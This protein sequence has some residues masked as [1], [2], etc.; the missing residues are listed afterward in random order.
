MSRKIVALA[1]SA[2][3]LLAPA[4]AQAASRVKDIVEVEGV[5]KNQLVGYGIVVGLNGTGD[6]LRNSPFTKQS[7]EAMLE[8]LGVNTRDANLNTKNVAAVMVTAE[9]PAFA[10]SGS[11]V[12]VNVSALGDAK[13]LLGGTL[14]VT[15]LLGADGS[16]YA[17]GQGTVQTGAV[18]AGGASGSSIL[19]G[20]P[21]AGRIASGA[22]VEKESGFSLADM[23]EI[24]LTLRNPD[25]TTARRIAEAV[26][27]YQPK[28]AWAANPTVVQ[29][30]P[31]PGQ[32]PIAFLTAVEQ[33][34]VQPDTPAKV[35]IDE[36]NG[37]IVM[38]D[39]VRISTVAI[40]QGNLTISVQETPAVSQPLPFSRGGQTAVVPQTDVAVMEERGTQL[41]QLRSGASLASLVEGLNAL[42]VSPRD[43]I[44]ILQTIKAAGAL[45]AEIEV[46]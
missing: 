30:R 22:T 3:A 17:V 11:R 34:S 18:S 38:S 12:D 13:S 19:K 42:G 31:P 40:A 26:N 43:M 7:L 9:L 4:A 28:T 6:S 1:I 29:L 24:R 21:T 16:V 20:V 45:Q 23:T 44:S 8:R 35:V 25:F 10:A 2:L 46:M 41:I 14:L 15:P 27:N 32:D 39:D 36:V 5:R 37:V 33:L